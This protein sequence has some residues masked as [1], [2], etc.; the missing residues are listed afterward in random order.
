MILKNRLQNPLS[1]YRLQLHRAILKNQML[2]MQ[3][4]NYG[5]V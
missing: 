2:D 3:A 5:F 4:P 1:N